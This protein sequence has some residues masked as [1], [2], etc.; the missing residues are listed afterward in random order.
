MADNS[1]KDVTSCAPGMAKWIVSGAAAADAQLVLRPPAGPQRGN[2]SPRRPD[3]TRVAAIAGLQ[4]LLDAVVAPALVGE[5][6]LEDLEELGAVRISEMVCA[7]A[8]QAIK[9]WALLRPLQRRRLLHHV[10][11]E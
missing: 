7:G 10:G 5:A 8:W 9:A 1:L 3:P 11:A 6:I 4:E 2:G